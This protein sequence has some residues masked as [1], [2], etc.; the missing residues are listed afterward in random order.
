MSLPEKISIQCPDCG[1]NFKTT[2]FHSINSQYSK[3]VVRDIIDGSLFITKC[4]Y[5]QKSINLRYDVLYNDITHHAFIWAIHKEQWE[6]SEYQKKVQ[7]IRELSLYK[8]ITRLVGSIE[9]LREKVACLSKGRDDRV[10][11]LCKAFHVD[12]LKEKEPSFKVKTVFYT[13]VDDREV[14]FFYNEQD[15]VMHAYLDDDFYFSIQRLFKGKLSLQNTSRF[16]V[17]DYNWAYSAIS[18]LL[19]EKEKELQNEKAHKQEKKEEDKNGFESP[20]ENQSKNI[21]DQDTKKHIRFCRKCGKELHSKTVCDFCG[22]KVILSDDLSV[23]TNG[24]LPS[25]NDL[26]KTTGKNKYTEIFL[27][28]FNKGVEICAE[29]VF[30][31]HYKDELLPALFVISDYAALSAKKDRE[32][33][34]R[35]LM[36]IIKEKL[37]DSFS[38]ATF[39][40]RVNL[41]TE[42]I[43]GKEIRGEW[44]YGQTNSINQDPITRVGGLLGDI[45]INPNCAENYDDCS[46]ILLSPFE[47]I[48]FAEKVG[49]P[50]V[51]E[52]TNMFKDIYA[53]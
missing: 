38:G 29:K 49:W 31:N 53:S 48:E 5:C 32:F 23:E 14:L 33:L 30:N 34:S 28:H 24:D 6:E 47:K 21:S 52:I 43:R 13:V 7:E 15:E 50:I 19:L 17:F 46:F 37:S 44:L 1:N 4:P 35:E 26:P 9:E 42:I 45:L 3:S 39:L 20:E 2:I 51:T 8:G 10:I 36:G 25:E 41:F 27:D 16:P 22:T 18:K 11:E 40:Q 12:L